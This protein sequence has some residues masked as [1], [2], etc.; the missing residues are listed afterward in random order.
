LYN[1]IKKVISLAY[2]YGHM[3]NGYTSTEYIRQVS[4]L[5]EQQ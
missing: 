1:I 3:A 2:I 5:Y 4:F